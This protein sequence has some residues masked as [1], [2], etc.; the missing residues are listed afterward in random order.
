MATCQKPIRKEALMATLFKY[1][2][3]KDTVQDSQADA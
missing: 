3:E 1:V 2:R